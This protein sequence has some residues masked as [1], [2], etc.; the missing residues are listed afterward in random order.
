MTIQ[1]IQL[2]LPMPLLER[3]RV[4]AVDEVR[5]LVTSLLENY[6]HELER[7]Q[8]RQAYETYYNART[9]ED[10]AEEMVLLVDFSFADAEIT[11]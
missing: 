3:A 7:E 1:S 9:T 2:E 11:V 4:W 6:V 5:E 10:E 8:R